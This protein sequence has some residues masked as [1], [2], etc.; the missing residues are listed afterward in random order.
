MVIDYLCVMRF[1][2]LP[3]EA[4]APLLVN[5]DAV[6]ALPITHQRLEM[7]SRRDGQVAEAC[8]RIEVLEFLAGSP[9]KMAAARLPLKE[10]IT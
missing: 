4:H 10:R 6:L 1:T 9:L 5:A 7:I 2:V 3:V 8:R